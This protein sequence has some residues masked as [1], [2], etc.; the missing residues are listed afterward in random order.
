MV[1]KS[2]SYSEQ[3]YWDERYRESRNP[4][5]WY[6]GYEELA[7]L[8][9][10]QIPL[11]AKV[12]QVGTGTSMMQLHMARA[13]YTSLQGLDYSAGAVAAMM[14]A[15]D[16][17]PGVSY[18]VA[19]CRD[20]SD[21]TPDSF[22]A[23]IDKGTLDSALC[24]PDAAE[25][26]RRMLSECW[27]VLT[28][29]GLFLLI[30]YGSPEFRLCHLMQPYLNW[31]VQIQTLSRKDPSREH[32]HLNFGRPVDPLNFKAVRQINGEKDCHYVYICRKAQFPHSAGKPIAAPQVDTA[33]HHQ[34]FQQQSQ[35][36]AC[37]T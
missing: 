15:H 33:H 19:D 35:P 20:L 7:P 9:R 37:A 3:G 10:E 29:G 17:L 30:T 24:G 11:E 25:N 23:I 36:D 8:L 22:D 6:M 13:G 26:A 16:D 34:P 28:P 27:R 21:W 32:S 2:S 4:F 1:G 31:Q 18:R 14:V 5:E 12:M